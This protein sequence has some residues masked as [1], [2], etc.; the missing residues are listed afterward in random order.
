MNGIIDIHTHLDERWLDT[1]LLTVN[2]FM[3][4][5]DR[6]GIEAAC[7]FTLMGFYG[8]C[9]AANDRLV[10]EARRYPDR[11]IPFITVDPKL[12]AAAVAEVERCLTEPLFR[13]IKFHPW[14]QSFAPSMVRD[15]MTAILEIAGDRGLPVLFHDGT[16]PYSTTFQIAE[17]ARWCP[18]TIIILGHGGLAD[19]VHAAAKLIRELPNLYAC[20]CCPRAGDVLHLVR[21]GGG[22]KVVFGSD[23][24]IADWSLLE[25][26]LDDVLFAGL[27]PGE[28]QAVLRDNALRLLGRQ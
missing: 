25:D 23:F 20:T 5:L 3:A 6:C 8:D 13:G 9:P 19:Y 2:T 11:L 21:A 14:M 27:T 28:E 10:A 17:L 16:P 12:G 15:T 7:V 26:R 22:D 18:N 4:G 24:G 1:P